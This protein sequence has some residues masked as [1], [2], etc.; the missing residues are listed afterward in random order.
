MVKHF[1]LQ[2]EGAFLPADINVASRVGQIVCMVVITRPYNS[3]AMGKLSYC[4]AWPTMQ[5][6][7]ASHRVFHY[8]KRLRT[9]GCGA[10]TYMFYNSALSKLQTFLRKVIMWVDRD[11]ENAG[12]IGLRKE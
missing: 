9:L 12:Y 8:L 4:M 11:V 1:V 10:T 3:F 2:K 5:N 7:R 6:L